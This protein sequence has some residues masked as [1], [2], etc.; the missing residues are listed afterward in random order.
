MEVNSILGSAYMEYIELE[1]QHSQRYRDAN[2]L[3]VIISGFRQEAEAL[4]RQLWWA[5]LDSALDEHQR[6]LARRHLPLGQIFGTFQFGEPE[7]TIAISKMGDTFVYSTQYK[8]PKGSDRSGG[9][10]SGGGSTLPP[11]YQRLWDQTI[12]TD[13]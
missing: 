7:V 12:I 2:S 8:W 6:A 10:T 11:E 1:A 5:D 13:E 9:G 3:T 4:L